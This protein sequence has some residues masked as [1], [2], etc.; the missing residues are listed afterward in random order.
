MSSVEVEICGSLLVLATPESEA[1][2][3]RWWQVSIVFVLC[4]LGISILFFGEPLRPE[5]R[6][7][8]GI[9]IRFEKAVM[10]PMPYD[11]YPPVKA[12]LASYTPGILQRYLGE[13]EQI[14][15]NTDSDGISL[16]FSYWESDGKRKKVIHDPQ[17]NPVPT[18]GR[19]EFIESTG[20]VF[21]LRA[22]WRSSSGHLLILSEQ[23]F[24]RRDRILHMRC[25]EEETDNLVF[26]TKILNPGY[27]QTFKEWKP[28]PVPM[29]KTV[30]PVTVTLLREPAEFFVNYLRDDDV[31]I[32]S[33][34]PSWIQ[35]SPEK[36]AW[37]S[38][39]T[40]NQTQS[41]V[42]ELSTFEPAWKLHVQLRRNR[43]ADFSPDER[44]RSVRVPFPKSDT[45]T[46]LAGAG[47]ILGLDVKG[48]WVSSA[49]AF[50][51][52][53]ETA[54]VSASSYVSLNLPVVRMEH[55]LPGTTNLPTI[56]SGSPF[57][58]IV[59]SDVDF[60]V[61]VI[62]HVRDQHGALIPTDLS[63]HAFGEGKTVRVLQFTP[64]AELTSLDLE[65]VVNRSL[66]FEFLVKPPQA[67]VI[68]TNQ[69]SP[70]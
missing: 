3:N 38:D 43:L 10:G 18:I 26:E 46:C 25:Y 57:I 2:K 12:L 64:V 13:R 55:P 67:D 41:L 28:L 52:D 54:N 23:R 8:D 16:L 24:P 48:I 51:S 66:L 63:V 35:K 34:D 1:M 7:S 30:P 27:R 20:F 6:L 4:F 15:F 60:N 21:N 58:C 56:H 61:E 47:P 19:I 39:A 59:H 50:R 42:A 44:W 9:I 33:T 29:S 36:H 49:G 53:G 31:E 70:K 37:F 32:R 22:N 40:G 5:N 68:R 14:T 45:A 65:M 69:N 62:T 11:S 17:G